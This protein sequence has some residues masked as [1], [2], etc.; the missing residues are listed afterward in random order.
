MTNKYCLGK[1]TS[2]TY[3]VFNNQFFKRIIGIYRIHSENITFALQSDF[4]IKNLEEKREIYE[5]LTEHK[6]ITNADEW[7]AKQ[8]AI[9]VNYYLSHI[10]DEE[11]MGNVLN[12]V[13]K[14]VSPK[15]YLKYK[16]I[17]IEKY[18]IKYIILIHGPILEIY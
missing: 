7:Y 3:T 10:D 17:I 12:W 4:I 11:G 2:I 13:W 8:I 18:G 14:N 1:T 16:K 5:Y 15:E 9:T 6:L